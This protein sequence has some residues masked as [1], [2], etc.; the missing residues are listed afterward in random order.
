MGPHFFRGNRNSL[1]VL[2]M[3][4]Q[5]LAGFET[6]VLLDLLTNIIAIL[7]QR[8]LQSRERGPPADASQVPRSSNLQIVRIPYVVQCDSLYI[9]C[10]PCDV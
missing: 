5:Q 4:F 6:G 2:F 1:G 3:D 9:H 8:L 7:R 10:E